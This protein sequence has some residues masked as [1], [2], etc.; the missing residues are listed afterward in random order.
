MYY[1]LILFY[2]YVFDIMYFLRYEEK[3]CLL[4]ILLKYGIIINKNV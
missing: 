1:V 2:I 3:K 4:V